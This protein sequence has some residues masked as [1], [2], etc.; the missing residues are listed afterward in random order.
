[1]TE[2]EYTQRVQCLKGQL[3]RTAMLY[4]GSDSL[5]LDAVD[6]T[7]YKGFL[8]YRKLRSPE[9]FNTWM[10]RILINVCNS[11]LRRR[12]RECAMEEL[13]ETAVE[14]FDSLP[15]REAMAR[16]PRELRAVIVL[17]Y[18]MELTLEETAESLG[19][20]RGTI[21]TRQR[22]ALALLRLELT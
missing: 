22:R 16:L 9:F 12:K 2:Q 3:Y 7:V 21:S 15:L 11:A 14:V 17:R 6:E 1:M 20:P 5:A 18:F 8:A 4:L 10:T 13:P 19:V